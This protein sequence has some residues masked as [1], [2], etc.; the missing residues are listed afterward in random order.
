MQAFLAGLSQ[1]LLV[2]A[3]AFVILLLLASWFRYQ[4]LLRA[5][6][7]GGAGFANGQPDPFLFAVNSRLGSLWRASAPVG[8]GLLETAG[9][10]ADVRAEEIAD[11]LRPLLR[12]RDIVLVTGKRVGLVVGAARVHFPVIANRILQGLRPVR[13][14]RE[15]RALSRAGLCA[16]FAT[17]PEN[18]TRASALIAAAEA[19][20]RQAAAEPAGWHLAES[21]AAAAAAGAP[22]QPLSP[23]RFLINAQRFGSRCRKERRPYAVGVVGVDHLA[24]YLDHYGPQAG[25]AIIRHL[26]RLL[27]NGV[28]PADLVGQL[29]ENEFGLVFD[30]DAAMALRITQRL[31]D[32]VKKSSLDHAGASLKITIS[33]GVAACPE[34][35]LVPPLLLESAQAAL[36]TAR[37]RGGNISL[38]YTDDMAGRRRPA[39]ARAETY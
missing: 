9:P 11:A 15:H 19:A 16:G 32:Q 23:G 21:P 25:P 34:H 22:H 35:G 2:T 8:V 37:D 26:G 27:R 12:K 38:V 36:E 24:R 5:A 13:I 4:A 33:I 30:S 28:R 29:A 20:L 10:A 18:G 1:F 3:G 31:A 6:E 17:A 39:G 7:A 14:G